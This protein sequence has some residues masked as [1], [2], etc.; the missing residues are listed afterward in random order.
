M[1]KMC[2]CFVAYNYWVYKG[3]FDVMHVC[4]NRVST[5][6]HLTHWAINGLHCPILPKRMNRSALLRR[7]KMT[8]SLPHPK[9]ER[10]R[11]VNDFGHCVLTYPVGRAVA[12]RHNQTIGRLS[13]EQWWWQHFYYVLIMSVNRASTIFGL[14]SWKL[15]GLCGDVTP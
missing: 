7:K 4:V 5:I 11:S 1:S 2:I 15:H 9:N 6:W 8:R 14:G 10:Q 3:C 13:I 12:V